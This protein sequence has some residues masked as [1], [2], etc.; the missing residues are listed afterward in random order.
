MK[1]EPVGGGAETMKDLSKDALERMSDILE[2]NHGL[3]TECG[4][5]QC[6]C[7]EA[8]DWRALKA[9]FAE[10]RMTVAELADEVYALSQI[11]YLLCPDQ[12]T[13]KDSLIRLRERMLEKCP[14]LVPGYV[15]GAR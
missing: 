2:H 4:I 10:H 14:F 13:T 6:G 9:H 7:Q 3:T 12:G 5:Q 1:F 8:Q 15:R 11:V